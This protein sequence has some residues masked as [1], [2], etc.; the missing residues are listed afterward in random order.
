MSRDKA[1]TAAECLWCSQG[2]GGVGGGDGDDDD[3]DAS[4]SNAS[5]IHPT[6]LS[7]SDHSKTL[8]ALRSPLL[9]W[10]YVHNGRSEC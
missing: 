3:D 2:C 7:P 6:Q 9:H 4:Q 5:P 8:D 1:T 10:R